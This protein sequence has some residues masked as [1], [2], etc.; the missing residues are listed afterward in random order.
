MNTIEQRL[1]KTFE[2]FI[3][4]HNFPNFQGEEFTWYWDRS[5]NGVKNTVPPVHLWP[6]IIPTLQVLQFLRSKIDKPI[7]MSSTYRSPA[8]NRAID[9]A[10]ES[11]HTQ[12]RAIDFTVRDHT[13]RAVHSALLAARAA[14]LF[15]GGLGL[16]KTFVHIDTRGKNA[17]WKG[18]GV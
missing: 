4:G 17:D 5:R 2:E 10:S 13:P 6:N 12:F 14:D 8:Y 9:G 11:M 18:S 16:Y 3:D 7:F 1:A 15:K